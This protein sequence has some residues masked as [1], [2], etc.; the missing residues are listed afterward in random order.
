MFQIVLPIVLILAYAGLPAG[1]VWGWMRWIREQRKAT[2]AGILSLIG[3]AFATLAGLLAVGA[4]L[5]GGPGSYAYYDPRLLR[6]FRSGLL[7]S[8]VGFG[9]GMCGV[10][11]SNPLRWLSPSCAFGMF[12]FW[13]LM[14]S[15]E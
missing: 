15:M 2:V 8:L 7:L 11:R 4:V 3:F 14:A 12:L 13:L 5:F 9:F 6:I 1:I 10:W